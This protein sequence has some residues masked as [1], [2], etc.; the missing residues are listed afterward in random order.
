MSNP[1]RLLVRRLGRQEYESTWRRMREF[2]DERSAETGDEIWILEHPP[3]FTL[4]RS[5]QEEHLLDPRQIPVQHVDRGGQVTYH[6]PGQL[7][8]YLLLDLRRLRLGVRQLVE[9]MEE[10]VIRLLRQGGVTSERRPAAPGVY[11]NNQKIAAVG[12]RIRHGCS[13]HGLSLNVD[14]DLEP[15]SRIN[16]CGFRDLPVTQLKDLGIEMSVE[17]AGEQ[18]SEYLAQHLGYRSQPRR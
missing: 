12:L 7:L 13:F 14:M 6:G 1:Q 16:P 5:A 9:R 10:S 11:V 8:L 4:G 17:Q 3:V 15:F 18:L 2:T